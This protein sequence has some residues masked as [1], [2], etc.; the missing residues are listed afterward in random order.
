MGITLA[1]FQI[2][3]GTTLFLTSVM[4]VMGISKP[5]QHLEDEDFAVVPLAL[6]IIVGPGTIGTLMVWSTELPH[7]IERLAAFAAIIAAGLTMSLFL[8]LAEGIQR[9]LG[10]QVIAM[11]TKLT[12]L[13]LTA[14][15]AQIVFTG[16][17][18][19][20]AY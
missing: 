18:S 11:M 8:L 12:A 15:A 10:H 5:P 3:T 9:R 17:K 16:V 6:P 14:L 2:G 20:M 7:N 13:V 1:A 19:F 4:L